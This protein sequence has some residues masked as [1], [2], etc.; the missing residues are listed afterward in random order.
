[1]RSRQFMPTA[2]AV[3]ALLAPVLLV[4]CAESTGTPAGAMT[5]QEGSAALGMPTLA[6]RDTQEAFGPYGRPTD[7]PN[8]IASTP[9]HEGWTYP[10]S[11]AV[12]AESPDR[13]WVAARGEV[14]VAEGPND[15]EQRW[16]H[17]IYAV[18]SDGQMVEEWTQNDALFSP[19]GGRG[20]HKI[21]MS[22]YD[23]E[24]HIWVV[25]D[26]LHQIFRF[27]Y[28]GQ[29]DHTLGTL[30]TPGRG[31]NNFARPT[32]IAFLPDGTYFI[33][34]G[35][36]GTRVAKFDA[37]DNFVMDWGQ[38]PADPANPGP[39]EWNTVHSIAISS[40]RLI[41]AVDRAH[42]RIQVFDENGNF[43]FMFSTGERD[44]SRPYAH[45][46]MMD[47]QTGQEYIW[48][49]DG[50]NHRILK[51]DLEGNF[52]YTWGIGGTDIGQFN[53]PHSITTDQDGNMYTAEVFNNRLQKWVPRPGVDPAKLAGQ[54]L[55][56]YTPMTE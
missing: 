6:A 7:W 36:D 24:K 9:G 19:D 37:D 50:G 34:D 30:L 28:D 45:E 14:G 38:E 27:T 5:M 56:Q 39:N 44:R 12:Y 42:A 21:K 17:V 40:D 25:D 11:A 51:F 15:G 43:Q 10:S 3:A 49:A 20:P 4:S 1:M 46:I 29:L 48:V 54:L 8:W 35:Y 33:S 31:P 13:I 47:P 55:R 2:L 32:D 26:Q 41:Y 52:L 16:E 53:G 22:P 18:N 23:Q